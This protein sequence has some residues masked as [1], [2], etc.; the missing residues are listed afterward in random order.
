[1]IKILNGSNKIKT[2]IPTML[3]TGGTFIGTMD[4]VPEGVTYG[5]VSFVKMSEWNAKQNQL[6]SGVNI[7]TINSQSILGSGDIVI[8]GGT[9]NSYFPG[10]W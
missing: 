1:M 7:K 4:D 10:G 9:G 8:V 6:E 5:K 2:T 3:G